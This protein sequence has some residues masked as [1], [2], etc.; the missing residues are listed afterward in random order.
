M[1]WPTAS[2]ANMKLGGTKTAG[3][4]RALGLP[5]S[6]RVGIHRPRETAVIHEA[7]QV[8]GLYL[9]RLKKGMALQADPTSSP[10]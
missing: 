7:P 5:R 3:A 6:H 2:S 1:G 9:N 10:P 8:A 4:A